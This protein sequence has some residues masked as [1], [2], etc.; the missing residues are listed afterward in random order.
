MVATQNPKHKVDIP[1]FESLGKSKKWNP[2]L[3]QPLIYNEEI[4]KK[5]ETLKPGTID[6][7]DFWDEMDYYCYNGFKPKNMPR[8]SGRHFFYLNFCQIMRLLPGSKRKTL[9]APF[10]RDLDH[11]IFLEIENAMKNG[12]GLIVLKPRRIGMSEIGVANCDFESTFYKYNKIG[13][14]AGKEDKAKEFYDK[15]K[16][17][18]SNIHPAYSNYIEVNNSKEI[19][20]H[21]LD[22]ENKQKKKFGI[23]SMARMKTMFADSSAFEG[24]SYSLVIFEEAGLFENLVAAYQ[25]T[26]PCFMEGAKQFGLPFI[27][28][29][30]A[31]IDG[32]SKGYKEMAEKPEAFNLKKL[33][34]PAYMFYPGDGE[35]DKRTGIKVSFFD[36][37]RGITDRKKALAY[38]MAEREI[39]KQ[40]KEA[41]IKHVQSYPVRESEVF[42]SDKGGILDKILLNYQLEQINAG[43]N[44]A[45]VR[46][47]RLDWIDSEET[48]RM[49]QRAHNLKEKTKI[50]VKNGSKL[51]FKD[52]ENGTIWKDSEPINQNI[53]YLGYKP[54]IGGCDSYDDSADDKKSQP[55][56]GAVVA[57]RCFSGPG[58]E[59]NKPVGLLLERGDG[60]YD[61]DTFYE[62]S[63]KM[64]IYFDMEILVEHTKTHIIRYFIDVGARKYLKDKPDIEEAGIQNHKNTIGV[65]MPQQVKE[66]V[67]KLLKNEVKENIH[68]CFFENIVLDFLKYGSENTDI[69]MAYGIALLF[70]MDQFPEIT[71]GIESPNS[72]SR[73][74]NPGA[75]TYYV[76]I[77]GELRAQG[78]DTFN[79][80]REFNPERDLDENDY[81]QYLDELNKSFIPPVVPKKTMSDIDDEIL[82]IIMAEQNRLN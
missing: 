71:E 67:T 39:A 63:V 44:L 1:D 61:D 64:A 26:K 53:K 35:E 12:Y 73:T 51:V 33:F 76:D 79:G 75:G 54:D 72:S 6:Y 49:L 16:D 43:I 38:I 15:F 2:Q 32:N 66:V 80:M 28:G 34:I 25:A 11:W 42:L 29:T 48:V 40:S 21:Y 3:Y 70:R 55:S 50:R 47:G 45:P 78:T 14:C 5:S 62:N 81:Q 59:F 19:E 7:D 36:Y 4:K 41:Y 24:G 27:F 17:S 56:S 68:K 13:I 10:Y 46:R 57:Y 77:N 18:L 52:D 58:R 82:S 31:E 30:G 65:K 37:K 69:A 60:S 20:L 8:I 74:F 23:Q 22:T 9:G